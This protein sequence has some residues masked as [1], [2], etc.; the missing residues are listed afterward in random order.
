MAELTFDPKRSRD[1]LHPRNNLIGGK[2]LQHL[3]V[4]VLLFGFLVR[5]HVR[6]GVNVGLRPASLNGNIQQQNQSHSNKNDSN[7]S[8]RFA[9]TAQNI[10]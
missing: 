2:T 5:G 3:N 7:F 8:H 6:S 10:N 1:E 4:F 9:S